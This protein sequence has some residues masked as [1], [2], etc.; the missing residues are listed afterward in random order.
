VGSVIVVASEAAPGL[1]QACFRSSVGVNADGG[2]HSAEPP[3]HENSAF[4]L[5]NI[6]ETWKA[7]PLYHQVFFLVINFV[8]FESLLSLKNQLT[9]LQC[10][11]Q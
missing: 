6:L 5:E 10:V 3:V 8:Y 11:M 9:H 1:L 7:V 4:D 2:S